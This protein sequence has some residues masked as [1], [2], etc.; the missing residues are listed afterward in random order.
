MYIEERALTA[1]PSRTLRAMAI[2]PRTSTGFHADGTPFDR[3]GRGTIVL[4]RQPDE[5]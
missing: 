5:C 3:L 4:A 1:S 2:A